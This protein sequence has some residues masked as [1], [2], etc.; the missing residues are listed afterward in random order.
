MKMYNRTL[1]FLAACLLNFSIIHSGFA[2]PSAYVRPGQLF[3]M[4]IEAAQDS[5][6]FIKLTP[7]HP[8]KDS[9]VIFSAIDKLP[10][11]FANIDYGR[12]FRNVQAFT[13]E[14]EPM[15]VHRIETNKW[16]IASS[17]KL[18]YITY[19]VFLH[20]AEGVIKDQTATGRRRPGYACFP[21]AAVLGWLDGHETGYQRIDIIKPDGWLLT[22][23]IEDTGDNAFSMQSFTELV[24]TPFALGNRLSIDKFIAF[25][26]PHIVA[27]YNET[28]F[29]ITK[30][31]STIRK[32]SKAAEFL[33]KKTPFQNY[34]AAIEFLKSES[35]GENGKSHHVRTFPNG[36]HIILPMNESSP[37][38]IWRTF[39]TCYLRSWLSDKRYFISMPEDIHSPK[40][41][42]GDWLMDGLSMYYSARLLTQ[43]GIIS[44]E[45]FLGIIASWVNDSFS[46]TPDAFSASVSRTRS[47]DNSFTQKTPASRGALIGLMLDIKLLYQT[48]GFKRLDNGLQTL[49]NTFLQTN[50]QLQITQFPHLISK[51]TEIDVEEFFHKYLEQEA[52]IPFQKTFS[53]LGLRPVWQN[54]SI[55]NLSFL[56]EDETSSQTRQLRNW[57]LKKINL[58]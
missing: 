48:R 43:I 21:G 4:R 7:T 38:L 47:N 42:Y 34:F 58:K 18:E 31:D 33:Y 29:S 57:W 25:D 46:Q 1:V 44:S 20:E 15:A 13:A 55:V 28:D 36:Q 23:N 26:V 3:S 52:E 37:N 11:S 5:P 32:M 19:E 45:D 6:I 8:R 40:Y 2:Q 12:F 41:A 54:N 22:S 39:L 14:G 10:L 35:S 24:K 30:I 16:E 9:T 49:E 56:T 17:Q 53:I 51:A 50:E 27:T